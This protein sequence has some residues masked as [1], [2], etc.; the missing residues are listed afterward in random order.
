MGHDP[1]TPSQSRSRR[2]PAHR[3]GRLQV[4]STNGPLGFSRGPFVLLVL[5]R[6]HVTAAE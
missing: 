4:N 3:G 6:V 5:F 2:T 1:L